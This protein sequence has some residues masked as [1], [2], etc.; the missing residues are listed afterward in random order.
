[1][2]TDIGEEAA[3]IDAPCQEPAIKASPMTASSVSAKLTEG[4]L[5]IYQKPLEHVRQELCDLTLK[6]EKC[7]VQMQTENK[8]LC[9]VEEDIE[10]NDLIS[11]VE[12]YH[13][14]LVNMKKEI[15]TIHE[16]TFKLKK[17]ALKVLQNKQKSSLHEE[18]NR[19]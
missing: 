5:S 4:L 11:T 18:Q 12:T 10:L 1:M 2:M 7:I 9:D 14:K 8:K 6:Q 3:A 16:R 19:E 13:E 17:R 15:L